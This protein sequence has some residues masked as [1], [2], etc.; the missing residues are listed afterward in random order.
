ME[1]GLHSISFDLQTGAGRRR[2]DR[3]EVCSLGIAPLN[4]RISGFG[5]GGCEILSLTSYSNHIFSSI[6]SAHTLRG[7]DPDFVTVYPINR[8][9][10][11]ISI[12][13][14]V[15]RLGGRKSGAENDFVTRI[16]LNDFIR[17][18]HIAAGGC[19][20]QGGK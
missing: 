7:S 19:K 1:R 17:F 6:S 18:I 5:Q 15:H 16:G 2:V 12:F 10:L 11:I 13:F 3:V 14:T 4:A 9:S 20:E 8:E